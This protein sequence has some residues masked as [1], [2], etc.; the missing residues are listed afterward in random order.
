MDT[1]E[2]VR[3]SM[4]SA[5]IVSALESLRLFNEDIVWFDE[6]EEFVDYLTMS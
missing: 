1:L 3:P 4:F 6:M 5:I 2:A